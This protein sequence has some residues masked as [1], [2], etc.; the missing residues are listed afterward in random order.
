MGGNISTFVKALVFLIPTLL[1]WQARATNICGTVT[2]ASDVI[3][4]I[5][6]ESSA[7][8]EFSNVRHAIVRLDPKYLGH[9]TLTEARADIESALRAPEQYR[10]CVD[11]AW[12]PVISS[13]TRLYLFASHLTRKT[14]GEQMAYAR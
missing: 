11:A 13:E 14:S 8:D 2:Y 7:V 3:V 1:S 6:I 5:N 9:G 12:I 10:L 4:D